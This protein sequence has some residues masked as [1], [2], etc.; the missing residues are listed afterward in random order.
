MGAGVNAPQRWEVP[1]YDCGEAGKLS[2]REIAKRAKI[3]RHGVLHRIA[4]GVKG[5]ALL[6]PR[7]RR[8]YCLAGEQTR[9]RTTFAGAG[10]NG[11]FQVAIRMYCKYGRRVPTWQEVA[12]DV[13][14]SRAQAFRY[15]A[16]YAAAVGE[17]V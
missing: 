12:E 3:S 14:C 17:F 10:T 15:R 16:A 7:T 13:G 9:Q 8:G 1:L 2:A 6:L 4:A 5:E 11:V